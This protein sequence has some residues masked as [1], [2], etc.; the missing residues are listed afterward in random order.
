MLEPADLFSAKK[1]ALGKKGTN[2]NVIKAI[3][4]TLYGVGGGAQPITKMIPALNNILSG[5]SV[6][7][8]TTDT[9]KKVFHTF[10]SAGL[11]PSA[12][13]DAKNKSFK[14][15]G[16]T[17]NAKTTFAQLVGPAVDLPP[18]KS[19]SII[20]LDSPFLSPAVRNAERCELFFNSIPSI[21]ASRMVPLL[22]V[23][24][25]F[26]RIIDPTKGANEMFGMVRFLMG[27]T[28]V[29]DKT[30]TALVAARVATDPINMI[31]TST[32]GMEMFTSPQTLVNA[33]PVDQKGRY[34]D[35]LDPFRPFATIESFIVNVTSTVSLYSYKKATLIIKLHDRSRLSEIAD[36]IRPQI[37][38]NAKT[39]PT[40]WIT[41]GW[42]YPYEPSSNTTAAGSRTYSDFINNN[43]LIREAYN[44]SNS[45]LSFDSVGQV[46]ITLE[47][48]MKGVAEMRTIK[49]DDTDDGLKKRRDELE[50]IAQKITNYAN[51]LGVGK[52][53]GVSREVRAFQIIDA[54]ERG[55]YPNMTSEQI[56]NAINSLDA[57]FK[58]GTLDSDA[59][60]KLIAELKKFYKSGDKKNLDLKS[61]IKQQATK[62]AKDKFKEL[63]GGSDPFLPSIIKDPTHALAQVCD[64]YNKQLGASEVN[65]FNRHLCSFG[66]LF[67]VFVAHALKNNNSI[68][69]LQVFFYQFN[70]HAGTAK[71]TNIAS[72]PIEMPIFFDQY[73]QTIEA[74]RTESLT[75]E[76]FLKLVIDAQLSDERSIGY[77][78]K[79]FFKPYDGTTSHNL[80]DGKEQA[81]ENALA[82]LGAPLGPFTKPVIEMYVETTYSSD[83]TGNDLLRRFELQESGIDREKLKND[84]LT[85]IMR[86][87]I[88]DRSNSPYKTQ[89]LI[90]KAGNS[91]GT[92]YV[93]V[94]GATDD[95]VAAN[96][97]IVNNRLAKSDTSN[98]VTF[99]LTA[100]DST[101]NSTV[102]ALTAI[103]QAVS[104]TMPSILYGANASMVINASLTSKQDALL[105]AVQMQTV[106][107]KAGRP[108]VGQPNGSGQGG[109]P[110]RI[111]PASMSMTTMGCPLLSIGQQYF[112]DFSTGTTVDN[113]YC[114]TGITHTIS[115]GKF[116]SQL[117]LTFYDAYGRYEGAPDIIK[118]LTTVKVP[119]KK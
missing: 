43:M 6:T 108:S 84:L 62:V 63:T 106:S 16:K 65:S 112:I 82:G 66:K 75:V 72:F 54:A 8:E 55:T 95:E 44:V 37:Y 35:V 59:A 80:K 109:L 104:R 41:Y 36:L 89:G 116:E 32:A 77:G 114:L 20:T 86:I 31:E 70:D 38:Q 49:I 26:N 42:R 48:W 94:Q 9:F 3:L 10:N 92:R 53:E 39:A 85:R 110:L 58:R 96:V 28:K 105:A 76:E 14:S 57:S 60:K 88:F 103:K 47:L 99:D 79:Q 68:D 51:A 19:M 15:D 69:E 101:G 22:E 78:Y 29:T 81:Y 27:G 115:S 87:H 5:Q 100:T 34:A 2:V 90:L 83:G 23:E 21:H 119:T 67:S 117:T 98:A 30:S 56:T 113:I 7:P 118:Y 71:S 24:F 46:T 61:Q 45:Q 107:A 111:I 64:D 12:V 40:V 50:E 1:L 17:L 97:S 73:R 25:A 93:E 13:D 102:G 33:T 4:D 74:K 18:E 11:Q 91:P 52:P